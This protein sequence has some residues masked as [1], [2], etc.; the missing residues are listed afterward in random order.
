MFESRGLSDKKA[1]P[2]WWQREK[3]R[4]QIRILIFLVLVLTLIVFYYWVER[5]GLVSV[6]GIN[7]DTTNCLAFIR[8]G[9]KG[10]T[11]LFAIRS[12]GTGLRPLTSRQ[13]TSNK[14]QPQW[15]MDGKRLVYVSNFN[16]PKLNQIYLL[17]A[18]QPTQLTYG[19]TVFA[20]GTK[21][22]PTVSPDGDHIAFLAQGAVKS[23]RLNGTDVYQ[24]MPPPRSSNDGADDANPAR[25]SPEFTGPFLNVRFSSDGKGIAGVQDISNDP[26]I[27]TA[28]RGAFGDQVVSALPVNATRALPLDSG[29]EVGLAWEPGG[30]RLACS[31]SEH[32]AQGTVVSGIR[33]WPFSASG[34]PLAPTPVFAGIGYSIEPKNMSW[35]PPKGARIAFEAW[36]LKSPGV[37]EPRGIAVVSVGGKGLMVDAARAESLRYLVPATA[38]GFP[39]RPQWSP[40]GNKLSYEMVHPD[41]K[42][43]IW[44]INSDGTNAINL[45]RGVGDNLD[46]AWSPILAH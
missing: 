39:Q 14:A 15:T 41:G 6:G 22:A 34:K 29:H 10:D 9:E 13:D 44:V 24:L 21:D 40:D 19:G 16:D 20:G 5:A 42:R 1:L 33:I 30:N 27:S 4:Q 43:D 3:Q 12:D 38:Q 28:P 8:Q 26:V 7:F 17:G 18:D 25:M 46:A 31:F 36:R 35:S 11:T 32:E 37:R 45:T 2:G 23:V